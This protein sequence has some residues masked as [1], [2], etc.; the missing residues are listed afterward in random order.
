[1]SKR[2]PPS[3]PAL[4]TGASSGLGAEFARRLAERGHAVTIVARR[5]DRLEQLREEI[6]AAHAVTVNVVGADLETK[7]GRAS[8]ISVL[9]TQ[10]PWILVNNAGYGTRG[11]LANLDPARERAEIQLNIVALHEFTL[12][13]LPALVRA[14]SGGIINLASTAAFQPIPYM[15]TYAASKAFV[16]HFSEALAEEVRGTGVR[17]MALCP[18]PVRSE[19]SQVAGTDDYM[20]VASPMAM[21]VERCVAAALRAFDKGGAVCIPG[22]L[23]F[24]LA[25]SVR[26]AP[27]ALIRRS[28]G[29]VFGQRP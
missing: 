1:M 24:A 14:G 26:I 18:G 25:E 6:T 28:I 27:R 3:I 12:A 4:V 11:A 19:F 13:L 8:V 10:S 23:N 17:V 29:T 7:A 5:V 16:L 21:G 22:A 20:R 9:K 15:A 2:L